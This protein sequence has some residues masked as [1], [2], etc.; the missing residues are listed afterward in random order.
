MAAMARIIYIARALEKTAAAAGSTFGPQAASAATRVTDALKQ[1]LL[2]KL[3]L[4]CTYNVPS[5]APNYGAMCYD[6]VFK[7]VTTSRAQSVSNGAA[8]DTS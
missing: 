5:G 3:S 6:T 8:T 2:K 7:L 4:P 1:L